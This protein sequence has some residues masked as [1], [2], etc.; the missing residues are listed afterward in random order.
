MKTFITTFASLFALCVVGIASAHRQQPTAPVSAADSVFLSEQTDGDYM[1]RRY[2]LQNQDDEAY[3]V[4]Y[5]INLATLNATLNGNQAEL[6]QLNDFLK[7]LVGDTLRHVKS[8]AITGYSSPDGPLAFNRTLAAKRAQ[9]FKNYVDKKYDLSKKFH[10]TTSSVAEDW[11]TCRAM[12]EQMAVPDKQ[13]VLNTIDGDWSSEQ[14]ETALKKQPAAWNYLK[15]NIL[16]LLRRVDMT[17][18]YE[19][20]QI[21]EVRT[22]IPQP[23]P[24]PASAPVAQ[25]CDSC[26][27]VVVDE[28]ITGIIVE[29]PET[30]HEYRKQMRE[31]RHDVK[32]AGREIDQVVNHDAR[33]AEKIAKKD[34]REAR[35]IAKKEAKAA[36]K[37]EKMAKKTYKEIEDME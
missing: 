20:G 32:K 7:N 25:G 24:A 16:P 28:S 23:T 14:K 29:M 8:I 9:D 27:C 2:M 35:K 4:L 36:K 30:E 1:V 37:A 3:K 11:E 21:V 26:Q 22:M 6:N 19:E 34:L 13:Y 33:D 15:N 12:V 17:I 31:E 5:R 18:N 10:V